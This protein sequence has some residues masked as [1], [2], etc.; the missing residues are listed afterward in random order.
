MLDP[1]DRDV[2]NGAVERSQGSGK[3]AVGGIV[4]D[5]AYDGAGAAQ[6]ATV[7]K[8]QLGREREAEPLSPSKR[9]KAAPP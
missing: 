7:I 9:R 6:R 8:A 4:I 3:I 5:L 1:V 2:R